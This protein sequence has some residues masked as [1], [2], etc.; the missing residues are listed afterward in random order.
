MGNKPSAPRCAK[1]IGVAV[2]L[3]SPNPGRGD[4]VRA[5]QIERDIAVHPGGLHRE[6]AVRIPILRTSR[7]CS[8]RRAPPL[9]S[10]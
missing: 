7:T 9:D 2:I 6:N 4:G 3:P 5:A 8:C 10:A 1:M